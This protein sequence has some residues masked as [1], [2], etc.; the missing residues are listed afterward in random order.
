MKILVFCAKGFETIEFSAFIDVM[1]WAEND[2]H[3]PVYVDTC[4]FTETVYSTF[5]IPVHMDK[6]IEEIKSI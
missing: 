3:Y 1:G 4:G 2:Y 5:H 6:T